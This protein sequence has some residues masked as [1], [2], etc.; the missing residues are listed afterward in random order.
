MA[1]TL[2]S[3]VEWQLELDGSLGQPWVFLWNGMLNAGDMGRAAK[4]RGVTKE[5]KF[6][7][8]V[9]NPETPDEVITITLDTK[10]MRE[11]DK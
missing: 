6:A 11:S 5:L 8:Q 1:G 7:V 10:R 3:I 2:Q 4:V 9:E